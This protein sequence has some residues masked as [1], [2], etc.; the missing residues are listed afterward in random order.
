VNKNKFKITKKLLYNLYKKQ[1]L[2][3]Y[4]IGKKLKCST[5]TINKLIKKYNITITTQK[6]YMI[7]NKNCKSGKQHFNYNP[8]YHKLYYCK[9]C[10]KRNIK[11]T[12]NSHTALYE[13]GRC[14]SCAQKKILETKPHNKGMLGK[15]HTEASKRQMVSTLQNHHIYLEKNSSNT[16]KLSKSKHMILHRRVYE[17]LYEI[18]GKKGIDKYIKWFDKK[19]GL[20]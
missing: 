17:Y 5:T 2:S 9:D 8:I 3:M 1:K 6:E 7:G 11:T 18:Y 13:G 4:K 12:I 15:K 19:Y 14:R 10:L 20:K 16:M